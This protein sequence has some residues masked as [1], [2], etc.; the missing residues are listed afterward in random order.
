M[1][2]ESLVI[3]EE[4]RLLYSQE[5]LEENL[6]WEIKHQRI[7][8]EFGRYPHRNQALG[9]VST[10]A[11]ETF[12][13]HPGSRFN[14]PITPGAARQQTQLCWRRERFTGCASEAY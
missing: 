7:I 9:R 8:E 4:A 12:L 2:S 14:V 10:A 13:Q 3:H 5:R 6:K 11:E 1:H